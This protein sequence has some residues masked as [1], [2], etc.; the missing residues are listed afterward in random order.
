VKF[1]Y[2][3][4]ARDADE[5]LT[6][7]GSAGQIM[8]KERSGAYDPALGQVPEVTITQAIVAVVLPVDT[9][10]VN[11]TTVLIT[12]E[13]AYMSA[14]GTT[15][16]K[17]ADVLEINGKS[18]TVTGVRWTAPAGVGVLGQLFVRR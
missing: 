1:D 17:P 9:E 7:F 11:G 13:T 18:Y 6:E 3:E 10:M 12:D 8:R 15:E 14:V 16:P 2:D 5:M 4:L